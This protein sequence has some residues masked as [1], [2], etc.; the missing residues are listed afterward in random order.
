MNQI[1]FPLISVVAW[2]PALGALLL[3]AVPKAQEATQRTLALAVG[4]ITLLAS[5]LIL[6]FFAYDQP[7]FQLADGFDWVQSWGLRYAVSVDGVSL[8]FV[9]LATVLMPL[10]QIAT[11]G[12]VTR[13]V[14]LFQQLLLLL[15]TAVIGTFV[16][17]DMLL[18]YVFFEFTLV[19]TALLIGGWGGERRLR[20]ANTFFLY[21]FGASLFMLVGIIGVYLANL[22]QT[23]VA[24]F[25]IATII[26]NVQAGVLT[27][28]QTIGRVLFGAFF[29]G[30]AVKMPLWPF[31]T[32]LPLAHAESTPDG[33]IDIMGLL[34]KLG[35]YGLIR[36]NLQMF[37]EAS[38]WT[39]PAIGILA[40]IGIL[41]G[42]IVAYAQSD[43]KRLLAYSTLSHMGF[44][45]LGIF[46]LNQ[47][48]V[49]G[50]V[51]MMLSSGISTGALFLA[52]G[53]L[54]ARFG[55]RDVQR[56]H[57]LWKT[58]P[59]LGGLTLIAVLSSVGLPGLNGFIGEYTVMQGAWQSPGLGW[60]FLIP[61]V[62]GIILAAAYLL[63]MFRRGFMGE[64]P[65][66]GQN[67]P[68]LGTR[69]IALLAVLVALMFAIGLYPNFIL[70]P[71]QPTIERIAAGLSQVLAAR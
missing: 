19:P 14:R 49:A 57:G 53:F 67:A 4:L 47:Q 44:A 60:R 45:M 22:Q 6:V 13:N 33:S 23:N 36:F 20:A 30:F 54:Q 34:M 24:T 71:M 15:E 8:W 65:A 18:F 46:A 63:T 40:V 2:L 31:H 27:L 28:D 48:G 56:L 69:E 25:D 51:V 32:W 52:A 59:I 26:G 68:D 17:Q 7:T 29:L 70:Q 12:R 66:E 50:A 41:Y 62:I 58:M 10:A 42:A 3:L 55:T 64:T 37:P 5:L 43:M 61:A 38:A 9:L 35:G 11:W 21:N 1:G 39:A 16:A